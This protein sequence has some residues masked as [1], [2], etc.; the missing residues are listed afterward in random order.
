MFGG[1]AFLAGGNMVVAA[2]GAGGILSTRSGQSHTLATSKASVAET[3]DA[4][5]GMVAACSVGVRATPRLAKWVMPST[6]FARPLPAH[7]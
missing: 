1:L 7:R 3:Q 2:S 5:A 6:A 4:E